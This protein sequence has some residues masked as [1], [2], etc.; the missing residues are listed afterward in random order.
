[1]NITFSAMPVAGFM[2]LRSIIGDR[3]KGIPAVIPV[4]RTKWLA[5]VK[6]GRLPKPRKFG[7]RVMWL[8]DDIRELIL[9]I[10]RGEYAAK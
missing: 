5:D 9:Q 7:H 3:R 10:S 1:M 2:D 4:S 8:V 6:N